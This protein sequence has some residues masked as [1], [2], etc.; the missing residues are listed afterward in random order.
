MVKYTHIYVNLC[1]YAHKKSKIT[2]NHPFKIFKN[3]KRLFKVV[4]IFQNITVFLLK[5]MQH[6]I[7]KKVFIFKFL[8]LT[9]NI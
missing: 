8:V 6:G 7:V 3:R 9:P 5:I 2:I 4:V 1:I